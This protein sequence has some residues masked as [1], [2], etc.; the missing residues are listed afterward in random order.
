[1]ESQVIKMTPWYSGKCPVPEGA[2]VLIKFRSGFILYTPDFRLSTWECGD[3]PDSDIIEYAVVSFETAQ[4]PLRDLRGW[5]I[6][7]DGEVRW[8][9]A[10]GIGGAPGQAVAWSWDGIERATLRSEEARGT[11]NFRPMAPEDLEVTE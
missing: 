3:S 1:M 10:D 5:V 11:F 7:R 4:P 2:A 9:S 8:A 6:N